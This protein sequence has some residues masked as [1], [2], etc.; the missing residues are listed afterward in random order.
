MGSAG[1]VGVGE[2]ALEGFAEGLADPGGD[3]EVA[4]CAKGGEAVAESGA[5]ADLEGVAGHG[6]MTE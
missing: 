1:G 4:L 3:V 2:V 6:V 5:D